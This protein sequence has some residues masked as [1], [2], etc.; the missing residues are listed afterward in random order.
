MTR[1]L[2]WSRTSWEGRYVEPVPEV[3]DEMPWPRGVRK[4]VHRSP[5]SEPTFA[6]RH[7]WG[8]ETNWGIGTPK[9][10][11]NRK[12][13]DRAE[14]QRREAK[15]AKKRIKR[16]ARKLRKAAALAENTQPSPP[17]AP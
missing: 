15:R 16:L 1:R 3:T 11:P 14:R 6:Q 10:K 7:R 12:A 5:P 4:V 2:D 9:K 13:I 8:A 17:K